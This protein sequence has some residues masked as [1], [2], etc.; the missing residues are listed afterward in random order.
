MSIEDIVNRWKKD[1]VKPEELDVDEV[2]LQVLAGLYKQAKKHGG[3]NSVYLIPADTDDLASVLK[4]LKRR[5]L[6]RQ[7]KNEEDIF[8]INRQAFCLFE[9]DFEVYSKI[10]KS[11][12]SGNVSKGRKEVDLRYVAV[13]TS[14]YPGALLLFYSEELQKQDLLR[15]INKNPK[16][17]SGSY[18]LKITQLGKQAVDYLNQL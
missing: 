14:I 12:Y 10:L 16:G 8:F 3:L 5:R 2:E 9:S 18:N 17:K 13:G 11:L 4:D 7:N 15:L 6:I 1:T